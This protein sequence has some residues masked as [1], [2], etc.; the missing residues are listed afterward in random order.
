[1]D[2]KL[3]EF[4]IRPPLTPHASAALIGKYQIVS[5]LIAQKIMQPFQKAAFY[6]KGFAVNSSNVNGFFFYSDIIGS[7]IGE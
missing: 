6:T 3:F 4:F 5:D 2:K 1:V 7:I